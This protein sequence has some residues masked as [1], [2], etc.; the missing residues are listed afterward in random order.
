MPEIERFEILIIGSGKAGKQLTWTM[1]QTGRRTAI[2]ERKCIG[3]SCLNI[4]CLP[5]EDV[6]RR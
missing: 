6:I 5:S 4:A 3:G 2:V 1:A